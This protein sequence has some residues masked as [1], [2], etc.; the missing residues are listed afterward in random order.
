MLDKFALRWEDLSPTNPRL[1]YA[2]IT[3]YGD[4]GEDAAPAFDALVLR[5]MAKLPEDRFAGATEVRQALAGV[6]PVA[7]SVPATSQ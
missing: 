3:G 4:E 6:T 7:S 1:I 2:H 5:L